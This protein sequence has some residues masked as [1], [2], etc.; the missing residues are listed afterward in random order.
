MDV[1]AAALLL[2]VSVA[3]ASPRA[4]ELRPDDCRDYEHYALSARVYSA[5][6]FVQPAHFRVRE[7]AV[8]ADREMGSRFLPLVSPYNTTAESVARGL[9]NSGPR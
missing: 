8:P 3:A 5:R 9:K 1:T 2:V 7:R 6:S 4:A